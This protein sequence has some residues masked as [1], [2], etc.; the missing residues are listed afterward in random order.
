VRYAWV[1]H[2]RHNW[3]KVTAAVVSNYREDIQ[4]LHRDTAYLL[5]AISECWSESLRANSD[6]EMTFTCD[7][8]A[9]EIPLVSGTDN[10][11]TAHHEF[12]CESNGNCK[13]TR[14]FCSLFNDASSVTKTNSVEWKGDKWMTNWKG[15]V[16][17]KR[18]CNNF[19]VK[20]RYS[21]G[22]T[23]ENYENPQSG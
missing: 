20:C 16:E 22:G 18:S 21:L 9:F 6:D 7:P 1:L 12:L 17:R 23:R 4:W 15:C 11:I 8:V 2:S 13:S 14:I 10:F 5:L 3:G 19:K